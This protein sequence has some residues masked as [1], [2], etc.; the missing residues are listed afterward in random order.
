M[1]GE[2]VNR[3]DLIVN[4]TPTGMIP[5]RG[6]TPHVPLSP[7]EVVADVLA[8]AAVGVTCVHLHARDEQGRPTGSPDVYARMIEG[9]RSQ[10][11][12][13]IIGVSCTGRD[14]GD[15]AKRSA[16]LDLDGDVKPDMASLTLS[17][18]NFNRQA[19][20]NAPQ[21][22]QDLALKMRDRGIKPE[23]EAFDLGMINYARYLERKGLIAPPFYFNLIL[24]NIAC[25]QADLMHAGLMVRELPGNSWWSFGGIGDWQLKMN[26]MAVLEGGGVRVGLEDNIFFDSLRTR[27]ATNA[28][29]VERI[30][31]VAQ[32]FDRQ[33]MSP[34]EGRRCLGLSDRA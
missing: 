8:C 28:E 7:A 34:R 14:E 6:M 32:L 19:S 29:L 16:V 21:T 24:G 27:P 30:V 18:L 23:L 9:L 25:A 17:S 2:S 10:R 13:L 1:P 3:A 22:I 15:F 5:T 12:D 33:V 31:R 11:P 4:L 26:M 20:V